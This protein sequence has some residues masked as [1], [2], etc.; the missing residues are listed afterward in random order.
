LRTNGPRRGSAVR[1][2]A[3]VM[4]RMA[5]A[6]VLVTTAACAPKTRYEP[7]PPAAVPSYKEI[8][9]WKAPQPRDADVRGAWWDLFAD[10]VAAGLEQRVDVS[11]QTLRV[12]EAQFA[13]ARA[14]L[15][16]ARANLYPQVVGAPAVTAGRPSAS[17]ATSAFHD[18]YADIVLPIDASY[19]AD[20]WG[21]LHGIVEASRTAAQATAADLETARLSLHAELAID[22]FA[23]RGFDREQQILSSAVDA[24][25]QALELTQ[26]RFRGGL[27]SGADVAQA[28][29]QLETTRVQAVDLG[30][31]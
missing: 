22:Y 28:E 20:V 1:G 19:E 15:R 10:P 13:Q 18:T 31:Q 24:F 14:T 4:R 27:A 21:R 5:L 23:L 26:N 9:N 12:A 25:A 29:T 8:E 17:R 30:V 3:A 16:G 11:N 6:V 2:G 7:P